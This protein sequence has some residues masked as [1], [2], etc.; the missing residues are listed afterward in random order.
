[1][2]ELATAATAAEK[3]RQLH[4]R[5]SLAAAWSPQSRDCTPVKI[6]LSS[7]CDQRG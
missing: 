7:E 6:A 3:W 1:M 5:D 2:G 4:P